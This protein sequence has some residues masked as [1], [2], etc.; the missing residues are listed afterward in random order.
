MRRVISDQIAALNALAEVVRRQTGSLDLSGAGIVLPRTMRDPNSGKSEG[1]TFPAPQSGTLSAPRRSPERSE[2]PAAVQ[3]QRSSAAQA[4]VPARSPDFARDVGAYVDRLNAVARDLV[5]AIDGS[6]PRELERRFAAGERHV[7]THR[8]YDS[9]SNP[10][11]EILRSRY[12]SERQL[13]QRADAYMQLF[14]TLLELMHAQPEGESLAEASL[15]SESGR[16]YLM[17]AEAAG[18]IAPE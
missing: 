14:E 10:F 3:G 16:I 5:E 2:T 4:R 18:R 9:R 7:Y 11:T 12:Q 1:A 15:A 6:F 17:L 13:R 8:L